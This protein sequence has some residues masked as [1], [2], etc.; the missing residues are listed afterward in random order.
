MDLS[1]LATLKN[2]LAESKTFSEIVDYFYDHFGKDPA[3]IALGERI[4]HSMLESVLLEVGKQY[5]KGHIVLM[6]LI[7]TRL[8]EHQ[9]IH[10]GFLLNGHLGNVI[11]FEDIHQGLVTVSVGHEAKYARFSGSPLPRPKPPSNN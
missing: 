6:N 5:F 8:A 3:F 9:F 1:L 10:G 7:L 4:D 11:Y 2:K